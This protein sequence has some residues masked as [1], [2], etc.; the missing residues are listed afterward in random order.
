MAGRIYT[1]VVTVGSINI[2]NVVADPSGVLT[3]PI[4]SLAIRS[5]T[6]VTY[7]NTDGGTTWVSLSAGGSVT[8]IQKRI[9]LG[10][11]P[12]A[13]TLNTPFDD[14]IPADGVILGA[15]YIV[16]EAPAGGGVVTCELTTGRFPELP[17]GFLVP[18]TELVGAPVGYPPLTAVPVSGLA[19]GMLSGGPTLDG[20]AWTPYILLDA[21]AVVLNTLTNFDVTCYVFYTTLTGF[22]LPA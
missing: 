15:T 18:A 16:T 21:G 14:A 10:D 5:D 6:A 4:G 19:V 17:A 11:L 22:T 3:A 9:Q 7:Q 8:S 1:N 2:Y 12:A 20:A 13:T